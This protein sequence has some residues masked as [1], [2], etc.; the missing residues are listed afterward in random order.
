[1]EKLTP[2]ISSERFNEEPIDVVIYI[3]R[4]LNSQ[5]MACK[6]SIL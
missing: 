1:M 5:W 2:L 6:N 4:A 3:E